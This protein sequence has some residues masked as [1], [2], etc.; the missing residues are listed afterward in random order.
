VTFPHPESDALRIIIENAMADYETGE[1]NVR[2]AVLHTA[3][4]GWYEGHIEGEEVSAGSLKG[5]GS[6]VSPC[7]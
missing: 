6:R 3:V 2:G 7:G 4:H 5:V 1:V